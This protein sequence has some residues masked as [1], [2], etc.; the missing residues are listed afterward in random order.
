MLYISKDFIGIQRNTPTQIFKLK[1][2]DKKIMYYSSDKMT[3][4]QPT[5]IKVGISTVVCWQSSTYG[6]FVIWNPYIYL[7]ATGRHQKSY[8][9]MLIFFFLARFVGTYIYTIGLTKPDSNT[10]WSAVDLSPN[11]RKLHTCLI[12]AIISKIKSK[13][14]LIS[15][16]HFPTEP[17]L[18]TASIPLVGPFWPMLIS[19]SYR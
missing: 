2:D 10:I 3:M 15:P 19:K 1:R 16:I 14:S 11:K 8:I 17:I 18:L 9:D 13:T 5:K 6:H 4:Y 12:T 7:R